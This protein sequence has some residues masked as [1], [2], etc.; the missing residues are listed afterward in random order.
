[1]RDRPLVAV[2]GDPTACEPQLAQLVW[3]LA[4]GNVTV[5]LRSAGHERI[6]ARR[7][8]PAG[9]GARGSVFFVWAR[10]APDSLVAR[11]LN[12]GVAET[13]SVNDTP[14]PYFANECRAAPPRPGARSNPPLSQVQAGPAQ[15]HGQTV[16]V[17]QPLPHS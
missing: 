14:T 11:A 6:A 8:I 4:L 7:P 9:L 1:L 13:Y 15:S 17:Y 5:A 3:G 12:G 2:M 16:T 10:S